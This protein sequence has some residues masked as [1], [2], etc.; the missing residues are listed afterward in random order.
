ME[1]MGLM[2]ERIEYTVE[3]IDGDYAYLKNDAA[4]DEDKMRKR[5]N[6]D[7]YWDEDGTFHPNNGTISGT[8]E[9]VGV[10]QD[11]DTLGYYLEEHWKPSEAYINNGAF[12]IYDDQ[13]DSNYNG[14]YVFDDG[15]WLVPNTLTLDSIL[16][17]FDQSKVGTITPSSSLDDLVP[18]LNVRQDYGAYGQGTITFWDF[19]N[20][21]SEFAN[22]Y[23]LSGTLAVGTS[24]ITVS[25]DI[26]GTTYTDTFDVTVT[27]D[28]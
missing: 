8:M 16:A 17:I 9:F 21:G 6:W 13:T 15:Q 22:G 28:S 24:T 3:R 12:Y 25:I 18:G 20:D 27:A 19:Y 10:Y 1:G 11:F 14:L 2:F 4:P 7:G 26:G 23:T 5:P